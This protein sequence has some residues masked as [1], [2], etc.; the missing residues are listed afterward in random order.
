MVVTRFVNEVTS[1]DDKDR[2]SISNRES[3]RP[4][5]KVLVSLLSQ[6][7]PTLTSTTL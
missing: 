7:Y 3:L 4:N 6:I 2:Q 5:S 1:L